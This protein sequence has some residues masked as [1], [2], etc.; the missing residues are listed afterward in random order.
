MLKFRHEYLS[1]AAATSDCQLTP[2]VIRSFAPFL[3][4]FQRATLWENADCP[5]STL[6]LKVL[7]KEIIGSARAKFDLD[8]AYE[9]LKRQ[10]TLPYEDPEDHA[11]VLKDFSILADRRGQPTVAIHAVE[12][13]IALANENPELQTQLMITCALYKGRFGEFDESCDLFAKAIKYADATGHLKIKARACQNASVIYFNNGFTEEALTLASEAE[14]ASRAVGYMAGTARALH[15]Q[16]KIMFS[17]GAREDGL[18][19]IEEAC[20][21]FE[22]SGD[23][24]S[25]ARTIV[26]IAG[27]QMQLGK[28]VEAK[29]GYEQAL[30]QL[31]RLQSATDEITVTTCLGMLARRAADYTKS[32]SLFKESYQM[33][34][35]QFDESKQAFAL[36]NIANTYLIMKDIDK[37]SEFLSKAEEFVY[38][39][40]LPYFQLGYHHVAGEILYARGDT[41]A[42]LENIASARKISTNIGLT[43]SIVLLLVRESFLYEEIGDLK[44]AKETGMQALDEADNVDMNNS[45]LKFVATTNLAR[46]E[47]MDGFEDEYRI[48]CEEA[49]EL[50]ATIMICGQQL[51]GWTVQWSRPD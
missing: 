17:N 28:L 8:T 43:S 32:L 40:S 9:Y 1:Q 6:E 2:E 33:S 11:L 25:H 22:L 41:F 46:I 20:S 12:R 45:V 39:V 50:K 13:A 21:I 18:S 35:Q 7:Y 34:L 14:T 26:D 37:A 16:S 47:M 42:A 31:Q 23:Q 5:E 4:I 3:D 49:A 48:L 27:Y 19:L 10:T 51:N 24:L 15:Q 38:S 36:M 29:E 30:V 44:T